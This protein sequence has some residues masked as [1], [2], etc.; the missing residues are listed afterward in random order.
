MNDQEAAARALA[1]PAFAQKVLSGEENYPAV[2]DA[3][4]ADLY[5]ASVRE[6]DDTSGYQ[7]GFETRTIDATRAS[8]IPNAA[9]YVRYYPKMPAA[10]AWRDWQVLERNNLTQ[11]SQAQR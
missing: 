4:L 10:G 9:C 1:D 3:I 5:D 2:R 11:L 7:S 8:S 6:G